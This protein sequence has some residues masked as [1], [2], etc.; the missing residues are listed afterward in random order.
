MEP[1]IYET[2]YLGI[3]PVGLMK[4]TGAAGTG[5]IAV[6]MYNVNADH[7][8]TPRVITKQDETVVWR[9]DTAEAFGASAPDQNPSGQGAFVF[10]QRFPGQVFDAETGLFQNWNREY[11]ARQ[12]RYVESDPIGLAGGINTFAYV[13]GNPL[14]MTD[15]LGLMGQGSGAGG[16][17]KSSPT[18]PTDSSLMCFL[19][20]KAM[21]VPFTSAFSFTTSMVGASACGVLASVGGPAGTAGG[22]LFGRYAGSVGGFAVGQVISN[23]VCE[24]RCSK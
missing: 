14:S 18:P 5:D 21:S 24:T 4:Q 3:M 8:A 20:C 15:P 16:G 19:E 10:N 13:E 11:N 9:W 17:P 2:I 22:M 6:T 12:G 7:I 23:Q 1:P